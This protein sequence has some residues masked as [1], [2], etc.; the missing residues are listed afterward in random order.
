MAKVI[1]ITEEE[2]TELTLLLNMISNAKQSYSYKSTKKAFFV[3]LNLNEDL[4]IKTTFEF[5]KNGKLKSCYA[6][7]S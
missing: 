7:G 6:G 3:T 4:E 5:D 1:K 2:I